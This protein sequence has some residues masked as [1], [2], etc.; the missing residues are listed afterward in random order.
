VNIV[1]IYSLYDFLSSIEHKRRHFE[2]CF[3]GC[4][5]AHWK[6]M[7]SKVVLSS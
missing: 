1:T 6:S 3:S 7:G 2:T 5:C 4:F